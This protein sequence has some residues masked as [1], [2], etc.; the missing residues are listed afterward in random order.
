M[1]RILSII[2]AAVLALSYLTASATPT[3]ISGTSTYYTIGYLLPS[4][5]FTFN[6]AS[7]TITNGAFS[8]TFTEGTAT[9]T[10]TTGALTILTIP[11]VTISSS[12]YNWDSFV[13]PATAS[14]SGT[15]SPTIPCTAGA[16]Y[17]QN[18]STPPYQ[19]WQCQSVGGSV[20]WI[21]YQPTSIKSPGRYAGNGAPAFYCYSPCSYTQVDASPTTQAEW[22]LIALVGTP[23]NNW[24][25]QL[26]G[27]GGP[28]TPSS[29]TITSAVNAITTTTTVTSAAPGQVRS[30]IGSATTSNAS[31]ADVNSSLV[32]VHGLSTIPA[33]TTASN[34]Y[35]YGTQGKFVLGGT[36]NGSLW[37]FGVLGQLDIS[38]ATLTAA[39]HVAPIWSDAGA[40]GPSVTCAFCDGVVI[41]N[42]TATTFNSILFTASK[43]GYFVDAANVTNSGGWIASSSASS[44]CTTTYLLKI[45]TAS[46]AGYIH[47]CSN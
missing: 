1:K 40:T 7:A 23:S 14:I 15:G 32:G 16:L 43:A 29:V 3:T 34:G 21:P 22:L 2:A 37:G 11:N 42:T 33:G 10:I 19:P 25:N 9:V 13:V 12:T 18:D 8:G 44:S 45:N 20:T 24:V 36:V 41:T 4:G 17:T 35:T 5:T 30:I 38:A 26:N 31:F 28:L 47:V 46:G 27:N 39:A 6:G